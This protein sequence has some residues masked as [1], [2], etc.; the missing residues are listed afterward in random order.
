MD[1][2]PLAEDLLERRRRH[3]RRVECPE[4]LAQHERAL[5]RLLHR[6]LLVEREADQQRERIVHEQGVGLVGVGEEQLGHDGG[7]GRGI[8]ARTSVPPPR[9]LSTS[10]RPPSTSTRSA[11][12]SRPVPPDSSAPPTPSSRTSTASSSPSTAIR[13]WMRLASA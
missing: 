1:R 4:P 8:I 9:G 10:S 2:R 5:E 3:A 13:T 7:G 12:P 6:H 11:R